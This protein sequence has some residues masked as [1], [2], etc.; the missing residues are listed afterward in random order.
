MELERRS[1]GLVVA[2]VNNGAPTTAAVSL[3]NLPL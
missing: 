1:G 2:R 3:Q